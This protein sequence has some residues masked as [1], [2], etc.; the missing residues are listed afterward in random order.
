V[1]SITADSILQLDTLHAQLPGL[2]KAGGLWEQLG[3]KARAG[4]DIIIGIVDGGIWPENPACRPP[5]RERRAQPQRQQ[6]C[7]ARRQPAGRAAARRAKASAWPTAT[8][9]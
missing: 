2:D 1:A 4:E 9:S 5:R 8:T 7:T 6:R 3:G